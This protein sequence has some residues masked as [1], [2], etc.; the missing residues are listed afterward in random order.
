MLLITTLFSFIQSSCWE[1]RKLPVCVGVGVYQWGA[2]HSQPALPFP[3][4]PSIPGSAAPQLSSTWPRLEEIQVSKGFR[5]LA[6]R[7]RFYQAGVCFLG[8]LHGEFLL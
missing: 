4:V 6:I 2:L 5:V 8:P 7:E 1:W 3:P